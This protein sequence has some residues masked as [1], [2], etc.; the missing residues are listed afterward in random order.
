MLQEPLNLRSR[1]DHVLSRLLQ[2]HAVQHDHVII[3]ADATQVAT[4]DIT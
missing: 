1:R 2:Q 3:A 4:D